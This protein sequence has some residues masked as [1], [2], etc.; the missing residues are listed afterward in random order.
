MIPRDYITE[1]RGRAPLSED[2]QVERYSENVD[3]VQVQ[4]GRAGPVMD[5]LPGEGK[6]R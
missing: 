6:P 3:P 5:A 1:W 4:T 2:F